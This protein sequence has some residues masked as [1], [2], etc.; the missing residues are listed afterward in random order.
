MASFLRKLGIVDSKLV[1]LYHYNTSELSEVKTLAKQGKK[2]SKDML[3]YDEGWDKS[4]MP[5]KYSDHMSVFMEPIP[6]EKIHKYFD[7]HAFWK[8]GNTL[9][10]HEIL[11]SEFENTPYIVVESNAAFLDFMY[12]DATDWL[13]DNAKSVWVF[14]RNSYNKLVNSGKGTLS[15]KRTIEGYKGE[16]RKAYAEAG[17]N[18]KQRKSTLYA[19][20]VPHLMLYPPKG[21]AKVNKS[22]KKT[23]GHYIDGVHLSRV[24]L[25]SGT[26]LK[27]MTK[28]DDVNST[29]RIEFTKT[30]EDYIRLMELTSD[31]FNRGSIDL[32]LYT[33]TEPIRKKLSNKELVREKLIP[34]SKST[35]MF[36]SLQD[37]E[38][39]NQTTIRLYKA[40]NWKYL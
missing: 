5:G 2:L 15:L 29:P 19:S 1:K 24:N 4:G 18:S 16:T 10:E 7:N 40:G 38:V 25:P 17:K 12:G 34:K 9:Y 27:P 14:V 33:P 30:V 39:I 6:L 35:S 26:K 3:K 31:D 36:W 11:V 20:R 22:T 37:V 13:Y 32:H 21:I 8:E 28:P 23:V